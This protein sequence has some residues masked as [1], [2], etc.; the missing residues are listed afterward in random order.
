MRSV[1]FHISLVMCEQ[2][3]DHN[4]LLLPASVEL[5]DGAELIEQLLIDEPRREQE[6]VV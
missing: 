5:F 2:I 6:L 3:V 1:W 4:C